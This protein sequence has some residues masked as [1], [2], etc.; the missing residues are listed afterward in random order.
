MVLA[1]SVIEQ[2]SFAVAQASLALQ[3]WHLGIHWRLG[4]GAQ[5]LALRLWRPGNDDET[6]TLGQRRW[7]SGV[8]GSGVLAL[9]SWLWCLGSGVLVLV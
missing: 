6:L 3:L 7:C 1:S 5:A 8:L 4:S 9:V 2:A